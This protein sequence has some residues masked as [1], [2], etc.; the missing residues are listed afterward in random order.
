MI[1]RRDGTHDGGVRAEYRPRTHHARTVQLRLDRKL[2]LP[3][4]R[5]QQPTV[6]VEAAITATDELV[7]PMREEPRSFR[8]DLD[9]VRRPM[10]VHEREANQVTEQRQAAQHEHRNIG[11]GRVRRALQVLHENEPH[12]LTVRREGNPGQGIRVEEGNSELEEL[13]MHGPEAQAVRLLLGSAPHPPEL[14]RIE[15]VARRHA[16]M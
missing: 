7:A 11:G 4:R 12:V 6:P 8:N 10:I 1:R 3:A 16:V 14:T 13:G 2:A 9:H 15:G 5:W